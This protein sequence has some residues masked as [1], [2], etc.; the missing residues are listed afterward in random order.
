MSKT[1]K[2][3]GMQW[4][5]GAE[6][7][8]PTDISRD[9]EQRFLGLQGVKQD[10]FPAKGLPS[11]LAGGRIARAFHHHLVFHGE[12]SEGFLLI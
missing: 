1:A 7:R 8:F 4:N 5:K 11:Y 3:K 12:T 9:S 10:D 6:A 2:L